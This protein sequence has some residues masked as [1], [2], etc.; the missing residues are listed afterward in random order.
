[1]A[2]RRRRRTKGPAKA[3]VEI[4]AAPAKPQKQRV[5]FG[6]GRMLLLVFV[7]VGL[8]PVEWVIFNRLGN[9]QPGE[10]API[11]QE[12][13]LD[14]YRDAHEPYLTIPPTSGARVHEGVEAG[15]HEEPVVNEAQV[16]NLAA[17]GV[18]IQYNCYL[19]AAGCGELVAGLVEIVEG[20]AGRN[21]VLAPGPAVADTRVAVSA[22]GRIM[23]MEELDVEEIVAFVDAYLDNRDGEAG[24]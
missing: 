12:L 4:S 23:K 20:Y 8:L 22:W 6:R 24:D 11:A 10:D 3:P 1:M 15:I 9:S 17:G 2:R 16:A 14:D 5:T 13:V 21:V 7:A 18:I 19:E